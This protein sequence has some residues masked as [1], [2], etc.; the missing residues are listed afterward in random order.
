MRYEAP[1]PRELTPD[2]VEKVEHA[3]DCEI[4]P[5]GFTNIGFK[6]SDGPRI[7]TTWIYVSAATR[8]RAVAGSRPTRRRH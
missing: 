6:E 7:Y 2:D 1:V 8:E 4:K 3:D 5:S